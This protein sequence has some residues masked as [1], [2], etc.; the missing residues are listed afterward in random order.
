MQ[1]LYLYFASHFQVWINDRSYG[2][3]KYKPISGLPG[4]IG[5]KLSNV[6]RTHTQGFGGRVRGSRCNRAVLSTFKSS[7]PDWLPGGMQRHGQPLRQA[8]VH[9]LVDRHDFG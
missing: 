6:N 9:W 3:Q 1:L 8:C 2:G 4:F 7:G 5:V